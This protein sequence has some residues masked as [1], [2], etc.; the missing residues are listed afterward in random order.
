MHEY[1]Y[2]LRCRHPRVE[3][4][5]TDPDETC[6]EVVPRE[7]EH[8]FVVGNVAEL[9]ADG[10]ALSWVESHIKQEIVRFR[11]CEYKPQPIV[12]ARVLKRW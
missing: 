10:A 7:E 6:Y 11:G 8:P 12:L 4:I 1:E 3:D 5:D 9:C 2:L